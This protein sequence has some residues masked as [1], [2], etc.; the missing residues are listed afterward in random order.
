LL[1]DDENARTVAR[2]RSTTADA[3]RRQIKGDLD[4][5]ILKAL[6]HDRTR[7]YAS[8]AGFARDLERLS[9]NEP[10]VARPPSTGYRLRKF[11]A[12]HK[13][14]VGAAGVVAAAI[15]LGMVGLTAG[16]IEARKAQAEAERE[17]NY[18]VRVGDFLQS[19]F[20]AA[21]PYVAQGANTDLL[22]KVLDDS[23]SRIEPEVGDQPRLA[24]E[25]HDT[26]AHTY[27]VLGM[28]ERAEHH[29]R[30]A[31]AHIEASEL[32]PDSS[33][34]FAVRTTIALALWARGRMEESLRMSR[35]TLE[36]QQ[37]LLGDTHPDTMTTMNNVGIALKGLGRYEEAE[38]LYLDLIDRRIRELGPTDRS[39]IITRN[40][41]ANLY[42]DW[43]KLD[44]AEQWMRDVVADAETALGV[45]DPD[46]L[47]FRDSLGNILVKQG[48]LDEAESI[49][50]DV[51]ERMRRV[52]G[53]DHPDTLG[54]IYHLG[55]LY[56]AKGEFA[57]AEEQFR[58]AYEGV[59]ATLGA[60]HRF[61]VF[62]LMW[63][64]KSI[65]AQNRWAD[66]EPI[67]RRGLEASRQAYPSGHSQTWV[68][69][70]RLGAVLA[71]L[72]RISEARTLLEDCSPKI[73]EELGT[74][75]DDSK[76]AREYLG[77]IS[78]L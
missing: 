75:A 37:E 8:A 20:T 19:I 47:A 65:T 7:R 16:I 3:L 48:R 33:Q 71:R 64:A 57:R 78:S 34:A 2:N 21:S 77:R 55:Q 36:R 39:T 13:L 9:A 63:L 40:N 52:D 59:A 67:L 76:Q 61:A 68:L 1:L 56:M 12:R 11:V 46:T 14:G 54:A 58:T 60:G 22:V 25:L 49:H 66:A 35:E 30:M 50:L 15:L 72:N 5:I 41:L 62:S 73:D 42:R 44:D 38:A 6:D 29:A 17:R 32:G 69:E 27:R 70:C 24:A 23:A 45:D 53:D 26:I 28:P 74:A 43:G 4:S 51:I 18:A 31:L 10:V